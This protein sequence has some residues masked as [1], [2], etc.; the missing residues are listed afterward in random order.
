MFGSYRKTGVEKKGYQLNRPTLTNADIARI[1]NSNE[2]QKVV[3][4]ARSNNRVHEVQKKNPLVN[5]KMMDR[6]NPNA[7]VLRETERKTN[8]ANAQ[9]RQ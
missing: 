3:R 4:P 6:L 2:V 5:R 8:E 7:K 9:K 1:I